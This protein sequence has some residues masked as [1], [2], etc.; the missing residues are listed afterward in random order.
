MKLS[1]TDDAI[2]LAMQG[3]WEEAVAL[4]RRIIETSPDDIDARNRLGKALTELGR[5]AESKQSYERVL[6]LDPTNAIAKRNIQRL[7]LLKS[8]DR[9]PK[10]SPKFNSKF[11]IEETGKARIVSLQKIAPR[12]ALIKM[13]P[14]D[15][16]HLQIRDQS[17]VIIND[18][19]D[20][21]GEVE[22]KLTSRLIELMEGGNKYQAAIT[23][24]RDD[25]IKVIIRE[26]F[27]H[28]SQIGH[29]SFPPRVVEEMKPYFKSSLAKYD[30]EEDFASEA[31]EGGDLEGEPDPLWDDDTQSEED[32]SILSSEDADA[33]V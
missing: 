17:L 10:E 25:R 2:S 20:Y 7:S 29:L 11:F 30:A 31:D 12:E 19:G 14:G 32:V 3:R 27:Q 15:P 13:S 22:P 8:E 28:P 18:A 5:Y 24:L 6:E 16:A 9:P 21:L 4:N 26:T 33:I 1:N 23:S